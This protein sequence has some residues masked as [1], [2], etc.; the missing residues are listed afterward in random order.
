VRTVLRG[1]GDSDII[2]LPNHLVPLGLNKSV[3]Y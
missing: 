2:S 3:V 1:G